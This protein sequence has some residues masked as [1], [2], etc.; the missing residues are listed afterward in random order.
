MLIAQDA[1]FSGLLIGPYLFSRLRIEFFL[2]A[3]LALG[4]IQDALVAY[5]VIQG[6]VPSTV[7][8]CPDPDAVRLMVGPAAAA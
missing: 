1:M 2:M 8:E 6:I 4:A 3:M 7:Y 5:L